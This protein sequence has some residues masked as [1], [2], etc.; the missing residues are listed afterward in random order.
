MEAPDGN[1][2]T[3]YHGNISIDICGNFGTMSFVTF[4]VMEST[5]EY[6]NGFQKLIYDSVL[7]D[8]TIFSITNGENKLIYDASDA[9]LAT[10]DSMNGFEKFIYIDDL[11]LSNVG[12]TIPFNSIANNTF[13]YIENVQ[14]G[15]GTRNYYILVSVNTMVLYYSSN[16]SS[17]HI[18]TVPHQ[19]VLYEWQEL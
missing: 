7:A 18:M 4:N 15:A 2:Y 1:T 13:E 19:T 3:F 9:N 5:I 16:I 8:P 14:R 12:I 6:M 17:Y 10:I 11:S